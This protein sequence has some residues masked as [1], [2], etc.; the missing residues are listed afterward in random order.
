MTQDA[1]GLSLPATGG[2]LILAGPVRGT[3]QLA[4]AMGVD[5]AKLLDRMGVGEGALDDPDAKVP[6]ESQT[7]VWEALAELPSSETLGVTLGRRA[8]I[9]ELGVVGWAMLHAPNARAVIESIRRYGTLFGDPYVPE[10]EDE[11]DRT[12][13][14]RQFDERIARTRL[15]PEYAPAS[16]V[17]LLRQ[18]TQ[19][20]DDVPLALEVWFQHSAPRDR[21]L[22]EEVFR[23]PVLFDAPETRLVL[24][25]PALER[26]VIGRDPALYEYLDRHAL[27]LAKTFPDATSLAARVRRELGSALSSGEPTQTEIARRLALSERSL[28]RH[29]KAEGHSFAELLEGVRQELARS[30]LRDATLSVSEVAFLLGYSEPSSFHRAFKRWEGEGPS[31]FRKRPNQVG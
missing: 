29:L 28:Q 6:L 20:P 27:A 16:T 26:P 19:L 17:V 21:S 3:F 13:I 22:H 25:R 2:R 11:A 12:V 5:R 8:L 23:C 31:E 10:I 15:L 14:H 7:V 1:N 9:G 4:L 24:S 18:L 30:Y